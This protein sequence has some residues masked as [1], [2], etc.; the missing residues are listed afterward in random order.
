[1][2]MA[3]LSK[4]LNQK[5]ADQSA[6]A[7]GVFSLSIHSGGRD[8]KLPGEATLEQVEAEVRA[9]AAGSLHLSV[10]CTHT[11]VQVCCMACAHSFSSSTHTVLA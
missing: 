11:R 5:L 10:A 3:Q 7:V 4:Y 9:T 1:M 8:V 6:A 2:N